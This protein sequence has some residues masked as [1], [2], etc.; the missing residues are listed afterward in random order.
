MRLERVNNNQIKCT[1]EPEDFLE[2][3]LSLRELTYGSEKATSLFRELLQQAEQELNFYTEDSPLM[4]EA[5]P[6]SSDSALLLITKVE[7]P[8]E[9]DTR[10]AKFA[11]SQL[12]SIDESDEDYFTKEEL[13]RADEIL[14]LFQ[15]AQEEL[16]RSSN[17][18]NTEQV[19]SKKDF[20]RIYSFSPFDA[21]FPIAQRLDSL[22]HGENSIYKDT[23]NM[24]YLVLHKSDHTPDEFNRI[25]NILSE[26]ANNIKV[27][28]GLEAYYMEHLECIIKNNAI[29]ICATI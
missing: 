5:I 7:E 19:D 13:K 11:P 6:L 12:E 25:C 1:L 23:N 21:I 22:Y 9:L 2:R 18:D 26:Y 3:Q 14:S 24:Y 20:V 27:I 15:K 17:N 8:D 10:F 29:H 4:I 28:P 16:L